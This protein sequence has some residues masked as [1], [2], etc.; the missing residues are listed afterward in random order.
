MGTSPNLWFTNGKSDENM[1]YLDLFGGI[2]IF[3]NLHF[4]GY[5]RINWGI[6]QPLTVCGT[7]IQKISTGEI[8]ATE[9]ERNDG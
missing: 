8:I 1:D 3:G 4:W 7:H 5:S 2:P 6:W 9:A